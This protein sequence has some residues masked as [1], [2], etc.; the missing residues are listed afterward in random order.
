VS[1]TGPSAKVMSTFPVQR[2][3]NWE[4]DA[5]PDLFMMEHS[6]EGLDDPLGME[7]LGDEHRP[8]DPFKGHP[9][10]RSGR[11]IDDRYI[12]IGDARMAR[13]REAVF[14]A[15]EVDVGDQGVQRVVPVDH[16]HRL[17][18]AMDLDHLEPALLNHAGVC[19]AAQQVIFYI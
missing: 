2:V 16:L 1:T 13:H 8:F 11:H 3:R 17:G 18:G 14:A 4:D 12:G 6:V 15:S 7:G 19:Q 10:T 5:L 9:R